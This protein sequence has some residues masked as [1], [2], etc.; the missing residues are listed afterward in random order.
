MPYTVRNAGNALTEKNAAHTAESTLTKIPYSV[1]IAAH[2]RTENLFAV[3]AYNQELYKLQVDESGRR[4]T[5]V[6]VSDI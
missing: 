2:V 5:L 4:Y 3:N 1:L 6:A